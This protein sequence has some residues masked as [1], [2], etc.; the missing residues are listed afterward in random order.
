MY[1]FGAILTILDRIISNIMVA[2]AFYNA[3]YRINYR[4]TNVT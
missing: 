1:W 4:L 3:V 2:P